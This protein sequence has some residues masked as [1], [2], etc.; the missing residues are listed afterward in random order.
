M[1]V[2]VESATVYRGGGRRWFTKRAACKAE[3]RAKINKDCGCD[4]CDH[5]G[6]GREHLPCGRHVDGERYA[7]MLRRL[8]RIYINAA[9]ASTKEAQ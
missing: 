6:Y 3:A 5:G 7:K 4:Y 2:T 1:N 8:T 9:K